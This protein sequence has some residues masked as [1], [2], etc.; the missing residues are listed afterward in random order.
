MAESERRGLAILLWAT[1]PDDP[2]R[3]ATPFFH[4]AAAAAMDLEVELYFASRSVRLRAAS[5]DIS[6]VPAS[7]A[8]DPRVVTSSCHVTAI[9]PVSGTNL[10]ALSSAPVRS[11]ASSRSLAMTTS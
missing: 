10:A 2:A 9:G 7:I 1:D 5:A 3:C 6:R 11:S 4:A 8:R